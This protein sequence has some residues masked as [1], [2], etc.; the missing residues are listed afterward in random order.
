MSRFTKRSRVPLQTVC[1]IILGV[2][3]KTEISREDAK[4]GVVSQIVNLSPSLKT[5]GHH[6]QL[7][8]FALAVNRS[9]GAL[10]EVGHWSGSDAA[11]ESLDE[12]VNYPCIGEKPRGGEPELS[13]LAFPRYLHDT[14]GCVSAP[15]DAIGLTTYGLANMEIPFVRRCEP[16]GL[17]ADGH[18]VLLGALLKSEQSM[19]IVNRQEL[20]ELTELKRTP[21]Q[22]SDVATIGAARD[23]LAVAVR[24]YERRDHE[25]RV[26][27]LREASS[28]L[29]R[30]EPRELLNALAVERGLSWHTLA[31]M[32]NV[33]PTAIRKWRRGGSLTP[34]NREQLAALVAFFDLLDDVRE[35]IADLGSWIEMRV[36]EDTTL[37]PATLYSRGQS[38]RWLLLEWARGY[39]DTATMLDRFDERWRDTYMRDPN[40]VVG[41][42]PGGERA[43]L[44][45]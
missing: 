6:L 33:T 38:E 14:T 43:I 44:P 27:Q 39:L 45:R 23:R 8:Q 41:E 20:S 29:A 24:D 32:L 26:E 1:A 21:D 15:S 30:R 13:N 37:T 25:V 28:K 2:M 12:F 19:W 10:G 5:P 16:S 31:T 36:R 4:Q 35:P 9:F 22:L 18:A 40:F 3:M 11:P 7:G 17:L 42:G 34:D